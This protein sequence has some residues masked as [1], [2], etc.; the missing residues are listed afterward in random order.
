MALV[1]AVSEEATRPGF[2]SLG[3]AEHLPQPIDARQATSV[4]AIQQ[5]FMFMARMFVRNRPLA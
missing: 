4:A 1:L 5:C 2:A 3:R